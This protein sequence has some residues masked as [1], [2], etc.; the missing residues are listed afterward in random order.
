MGAKTI[1]KYV[2]RS[3][4]CNVEYCTLP[5]SESSRPCED[6]ALKFLEVRGSVFILVGMSNVTGEDL[7]FTAAAEPLP[8]VACGIASKLK[9]TTRINRSILWTNVI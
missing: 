1:S 5:V 4:T 7:L 3:A 2:A 9:A 6:T 8:A